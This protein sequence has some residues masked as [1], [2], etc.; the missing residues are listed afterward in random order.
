MARTHIFGFPRVGARRDLKFALEAFWRGESNDAT[1]YATGARLREAHWRLQRAAGIDCLAA[2]DFSWYDHVLDMSVRLG[3]VPKRFGFDG[4]GLTPARYFELARGN[5]AEPAMEL[6]KWF[7]TNYHYLVPELEETTRFEASCAPLLDEVREARQHGTEVKPVL[8]G[9]V[10]YLWLSKRIDGGDRLALLPRLLAAYE[11][12]LGELARS[13]VEWVQLDEPALCTDLDATWL[14][15]FEATYRRI[16]RSGPKVLVAT[17]FGSATEHAPRLAALPVHG[18]HLD[19]V[20][21]PRQLDA[22]LRELRDDT[23]LSAGIVDG[24]NVWRTDLRA[25][26][27]RL[28]PVH[29]ALGDRL[30]IAPSCS[31]LHVPVSL[32][33]ETRLDPQIKP[34]LAF[35]TEKLREVAGIARGL[36]DGVQAIASEL[37]AADEALGA[38]R[39]AKRVV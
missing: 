26:I 36:D 23:V 30:W 3:A 20:R 12:L 24:R 13:G 15:A 29:E 27:D 19:L 9:P 39:T 6:T 28:R 17:Y 35:A 4:A 38:R 34:W 37:A 8:V 18:W 2:G 16:A 10:T 5:R 1:L 7:D 11:T 32:E 33:H 22:W 31:L 25:A 14:A 21:A